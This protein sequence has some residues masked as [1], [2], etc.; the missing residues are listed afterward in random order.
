M[1]LELLLILIIGCFLIYASLKTNSK[2]CPK[3]RVVYRNAPKTF[4]Q[5][6]LNPVPVSQIFS[7]LFNNPSVFIGAN[8]ETTTNITPNLPP[9]NAVYAT[10]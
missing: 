4:A 9:S 7:D 5:E 8:T 10:N 3:P 2:E 1:S 6:Q